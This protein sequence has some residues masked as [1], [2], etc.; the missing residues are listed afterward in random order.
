MKHFLYNNF[1]TSRNLG[2][3]RNVP[4][5][6]NFPN[7]ISGYKS[8]KNQKKN[9]SKVEESGDRVLVLLI[10]QSL[11]RNKMNSAKLTEI[12]N[13]ILMFTV[14]RTIAR[15]MNDTEAEKQLTEHFIQFLKSI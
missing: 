10:G 7:K 3:R 14:N 15:E 9:R 2:G 1:A 4:G 11:E 5:Q 12:N 8:R 13:K 6:D